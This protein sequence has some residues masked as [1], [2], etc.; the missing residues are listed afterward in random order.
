MPTND[1]AND[2]YNPPNLN[3]KDFERFTFGELEVNE[4]FWQTNQP[5]DNY[6]WRK[7]NQTQA[8]NLRKQTV[9]NFESKTVVYQKI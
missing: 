6:S 5:G 4:L 1:P 9:H 3:S 8:Q 7:I 2:M